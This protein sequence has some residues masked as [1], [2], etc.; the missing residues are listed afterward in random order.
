MDIL[1]LGVVDCGV[2]LHDLI[3]VEIHIPD[4]EMFF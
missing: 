4:E 2:D 1:G 3:F